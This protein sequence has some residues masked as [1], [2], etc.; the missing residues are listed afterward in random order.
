[1]DLLAEAG[2]GRDPIISQDVANRD[3]NL[4][5]QNTHLVMQSWVRTT[6]GD[7]FLAPSLSAIKQ[8]GTTTDP[9]STS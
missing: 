8:L 5:P 7:Y 4:T 3:F 1:M 2:D 9:P 6:G